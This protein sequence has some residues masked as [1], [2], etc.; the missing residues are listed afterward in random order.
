MDTAKA[1]NAKSAKY[2][3][4]LDPF[5]ADFAIFA[6]RGFRR[7][8]TLA[9]WMDTAKALNAKS[10]KNAKELDSFFAAFAVFAV[11]GFQ[12]CNTHAP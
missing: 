7:C 8:N 4:G 5:F 12:R 2:A 10:A 6:V 3:K 11:R 9:R 1:L